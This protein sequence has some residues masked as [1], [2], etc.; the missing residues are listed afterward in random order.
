MASMVRLAPSS[1]ARGVALAKL[2]RAPLV[3]RRRGWATNRILYVGLPVSQI[4]DIPQHLVE[5]FWPLV[6]PFL[7]EALEVHPHLEADGL[8]ALLLSGMA[9]LL[10]ILEADCII[11]AVVME[12]QRYPTKMVGNIVALGLDTGSWK[13]KGDAVTD[14]LEQWCRSRNLG[15]LN[16]LGRAGWSKFVTRR[17]WRTQP[18]LLAW[19]ELA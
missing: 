18:S 10:V 3:I 1:H 15:T 8:R 4:R 11:G 7:S 12:T 6:E 19:K 16:M 2:A 17:G 13:T 14:A 9:E 5:T